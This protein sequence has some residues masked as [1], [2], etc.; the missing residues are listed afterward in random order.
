VAGRVLVAECIHEVCSFNPVPTRYDDFIVNPGERLLA[1]HRGIGSE[2][3]GALEVFA[4]HPG[5][6]VVPA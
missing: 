3:A 2:V 6:E 5:L 4:Q 1:Y